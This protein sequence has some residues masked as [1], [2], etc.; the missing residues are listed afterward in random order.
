MVVLQTAKNLQNPCH[1][2][3]KESVAVWIMQAYVASGLCKLLQT[4]RPMCST[5]V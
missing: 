3:P 1:R 4:G 2:A 5:Y